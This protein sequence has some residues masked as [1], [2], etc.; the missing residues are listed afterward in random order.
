MPVQGVKSYALDVPDLQAGVRFYSDA[1]LSESVAAD[2]ARFRCPGELHDAVVLRGG[3]D[4]KRLRYV[5]LRAG[6]L[7]TTARDAERAGGRIITRPDDLADTNSDPEIW[8]EDPH[9][10]VIQLVDQPAPRRLPEREPHVTNV[11]GS[12]LRLNRSA[13][14][15]RSHYAPTTPLRLGH[16]LLFT[17]N[18]PASVAFVT[19]GLGMALA[20]HSGEGIAFCCA[21]KDSEHHVLA[22]AK[23]GDI[24]FHHA[25][26]AVSDPDAVGRAGR[27][28]LE[29]SGR[30][31][32]GFGR[33]TIGSNFFHYVQDPWGSW[34]E[35]Y[36]DMDFLEDA[37][38]WRATDYAPEDALASWGPPVPPDFVHNYEIGAPFSAA[39]LDAA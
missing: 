9:G 16:V 35:Y 37:T 31:D 7:A 24:G 1:G 36:S 6:D 3:A 17:P 39:T 4:R 20:D 30:G 27:T 38:L 19:D 34:F 2:V 26:F 12:T 5:T 33:H 21:R 29:K 11:A 14:L 28:L 13:I 10:L 32:W 15:P 23:A 18:V 25:S 8:L 22:F